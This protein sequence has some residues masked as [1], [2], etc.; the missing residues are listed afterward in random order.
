MNPRVLQVVLTLNPGGTERLVVDIV[1]RLRGDI[2]TA[3][4]CLD[5]DGAWAGELRDDG[6]EVVALRRRAGFRPSL[7]R[8]IA[9][10]ARRHRA[11]VIHAHHYSP[12]V[13]A[14]LG[15]LAHPGRRP[16]VI[17]TEHGRL[18]NARVSVKR[19][20]ANQFLSR[21]PHDVFA[22]SEHLKHHLVDEGFSTSQVG[23]IYNG[24]AAGSLPDARVRACMR[25]KLAIPID[26]LAVV[27]VARLDPVK[28]LDTMIRA[29]A[30]L[31]GRL[32][33]LLVVVGDGAER[34]RLEALAAEVGAGPYVRFLGHREDARDLLAGFDVYAN[35]STHEGVSLT[36]LEAM[37]AGLPVVATEVGGTPEIVD[38]GCGRLVPARDPHALANGLAAFVSNEALRE[39]LGRVGR[40]R[41]EQRFT[42]ERMVGEYRDAYYRAS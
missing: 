3:V 14:C 33:V 20:I 7:G 25:E 40:Q 12:F 16:N 13:Y 22:V 5:E 28:D 42:I 39:E 34:G 26:T 8:R 24:I 1:Q 30:I 11:T 35:S 38:A 15:R 19:R 21:I 41:V 36:I 23:V 37:A 17:F 2:P 29:T 31:A 6:I 18:A 32:P 9:S 27:T 10:A 4:C